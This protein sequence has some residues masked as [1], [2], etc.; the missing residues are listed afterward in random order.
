MSMDL[1]FATGR[2]PAVVANLEGRGPLV[3]DEDVVAFAFRDEDE[4]RQYRSQPL[5]PGIRA[6][7]LAAVRRMG[8]TAEVAE[9]MRHVARLDLD[10]FFLHVD[11]DVLDD[12]IMPAVD[13]RLP[14]G[15]SAVELRHVLRA[16]ASSGRLA[17]LEVTI[18]NP[19]L[20]HDG[21]AG[22]LLADAL[23]DGLGMSRRV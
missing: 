11:A 18:Y 4:Q 12:T 13:Y 23:V 19:A 5:A 1:A 17:G 2:G 6:L 20:D 22:R 21:S 10:G 3:R 16:A 14:G 15:L 9:A 8:I 7:D